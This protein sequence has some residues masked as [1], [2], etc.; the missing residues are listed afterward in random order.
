[1]SRHHPAAVQ[2]RAGWITRDLTLVELRTA[3]AAATY[4]I[5]EPSAEPAIATQRQLLAELDD[6]L[7]PR[8]RRTDA[9]VLAVIGGSTGAGKSTLLN[10]LIRAPVSPAGPLRPTTRS[11]V[12][13]CHPIDAAWFAEP[14][15]LPGLRRSNRPGDRML[16]IVH[17]TG[18]TPGLALLD[19]PDIDS[20]DDH[21]RALASELL[22]AADLWLFVTTAARYAD[23]VP[24]RVLAAGRQRGTAVCVVLDRVPAADQQQVFGHFAHMLATQGLGDVAVFALTESTLDGHGMLAE[25][26]VA[27]IKQWI[28]WISRDTPRR[29]ALTRQTLAGAIA[30][31]VRRTQ[32]LALAADDQVRAVVALDAQ[33][34]VAFG[35]ACTRVDASL[36]G[37]LLRGDVHARLRD[38]INNGDLRRAHRATTGPR[39][40]QLTA[41]LADRP[42]PGRRFHAAVGAALVQLIVDAGVDAAQECHNAW[43][44]DP[45]GH[46]LLA[47]A[48]GLADP[49]PR[50]PDLAADVVRAWQEWLTTAARA[51]SPRLRGRTRSYTTA[52]TALVMTV[53]ALAPPPAEI[54]GAAA[55]PA[56][57]RAIAESGP[58]RHLGDQ[59]RAELM[60]LVNHL[61][62]VRADQRRAPVAGAGVDPELA[63]RLRLAANHVIESGLRRG[64]S[65][66]TR[67][68][69][70]A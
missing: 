37:G 39:R 30:D 14:A 9:P 53:A 33:V 8:L 27:P 55:G 11:P 35:N 54:I 61:F 32:T 7:I 45:A 15:V 36:R 25:T 29:Q 28:D 1:M 43:R 23:A 68:G 49:D 2:A 56:T 48:P 62:A 22:A 34:R 60:S 13:A 18:L 58:L 16:Q 38:L 64:T 3:I 50:L 46:A 63:H 10:S 12:L 40:T 4:P 52:A 70:A 65:A 5:P 21:N 47:Q 69:D 67:V 26:E 42:P 41:A 44:D 20:V 19:A 17:A 59:A 31:V 6:Y 24:W 51:Q 66:P 57:L